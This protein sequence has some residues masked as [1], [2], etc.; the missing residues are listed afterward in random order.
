MKKIIA[1]L[2]LGLYVVY[3]AAGTASAVTTVNKLQSAQAAAIEA[4]T[5]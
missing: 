2:G 4:A 5:K 1:I 3:L